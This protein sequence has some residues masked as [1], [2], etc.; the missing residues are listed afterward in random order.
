[1]YK[2]KVVDKSDFRILN[3]IAQKSSLKEF[4][5]GGS[6][7]YLRQAKKVG[8]NFKPRDYDLAIIGG[9]RKYESIKK[10]LQKNKFEIV[11]S[12]PYWL[13]F[14]KVFQII[15]KKG[16]IK[17]DIAIIKKLSYLGHFNFECIL[18]HFPSGK[19]YD[20][21]N[22]LE[23]IKQKKILLV[24]P[25]KKEN[26][27]ILTSRFLKLCA[28]F[29][30]DFVKE[31]KLLSLSKI[32]KKYIRLWEKTDPFHGKYAREHFYFGVL[33]AILRSKN[34][35]DFIDKL[36]KSGLLKIIF[37]EINKNLKHPNKF[38]GEIENIN[39]PRDLVKCLNR[40]IKNDKKTADDFDKR[41]RIILPRL[42]SS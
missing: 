11:K 25:T 37:P 29:D 4:W 22:A 1:M 8:I 39:T 5:V 7:T 18:W 17:L 9:K 24:I 6:I 23:D 28:R 2:I 36:Q 20:P 35:S 41:L 38:T 30:I 21:Y 31:K 12:G 16:R 40:L 26:P 3:R 10:I 33:Q 19:I 42:K 13:K 27:L 14:R 32:L 15:A 34:R